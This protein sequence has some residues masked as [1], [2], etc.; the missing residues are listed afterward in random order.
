M[1]DTILGLFQ[2]LILVKVGFLIV[3]ALYIAFILVVYKQAKAMQNVIDDA[4]T[5]GLID[6]VALINIIAGIIIFIA[7]L[8]I[9]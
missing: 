2:G 6:T 4:G 9:L 1:L 7:A 3:N 8:I 5:S